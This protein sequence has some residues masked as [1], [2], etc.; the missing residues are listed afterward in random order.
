MRVFLAGNLVLSPSGTWPVAPPSRCV[1]SLTC[2]IS[3]H[4]VAPYAGLAPV[5]E[6]VQSWH[7]CAC[8]CGLSSGPL[9]SGNKKD[10]M[11]LRHPRGAPD[12][13]HH[14]LGSWHSSACLHP[15]F[16][17]AQTPQWQRP[18]WQR[19]KAS[20]G[21]LMVHALLKQLPCRSI[22]AP[23][24]RYINANGR[25]STIVFTAFNGSVLS[26]GR[27]KPEPLKAALQPEMPPFQQRGNVTPKM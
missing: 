15:H 20:K 17:P 12:P 27:W 10:Q 14:R 11:G 3:R 13:G 8:T 22:F 18:P 2:R 25:A 7:E 26:A 5:D 1:G 6:G 16:A 4:K 23:R 21:T 9:V 19:S 24:S